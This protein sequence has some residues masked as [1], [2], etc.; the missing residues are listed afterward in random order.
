LLRFLDEQCGFGKD[1]AR[2][3]LIEEPLQPFDP[4]YF[5]END[6]G[7]FSYAAAWAH[8]TGALESTPPFIDLSPARV[9]PLQ[10][11]E[12]SFAGLRGFWR[13]PIKA[14]LRTLAGIDRGALDTDAGADREPLQATTDR[15]ERVE[16]RLA[17]T[18]LESGESA[19]PATMPEELAASGAFAAGAIGASTYAAARER[20]QPVLAKVREILGP[21]ARHR[22]CA[23]AFECLGARLT[24]TVSDVFECAGGRRVLLGLSLHRAAEFRD[25]VPF[26]I[27]WAALRLSGVAAECVFIEF[28]KKPASSSLSKAFAAQSPEQWR[29][30]FETL[31]KLALESV[32]R[33]LLFPAR[34]AW[35]WYN[36]EPDKRWDKARSAWEGSDHHIGER[37]HAPGYAQLFARDLDF[38]DGESAASGAFAAACTLVAGVLD[39]GHPVLLAQPRTEAA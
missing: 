27:D 32:E 30:G 35:A 28:D 20:A 37:D 6:R 19:L 8:R 18:A 33:P 24:G 34:T 1:D 36:A 31:L 25:L 3:W 5:R 2:P 21:D 26:F 10:S 16:W 9:V 12:L 17:M 7:L 39:P 38:L 22:P 4:K 13:D 23:V 11:A 14:Q 15:R 29:T